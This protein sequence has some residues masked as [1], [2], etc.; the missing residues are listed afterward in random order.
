MCRILLF[1]HKRE[2]NSA[3]EDNLNGPKGITLSEISQKE[4]GKYSMISLTYG[5]SKSQKLW[6]PRAE[7][8][9]QGLWGREGGWGDA[10]QR[11]QTLSCKISKLWRSD[12]WC[13]DY[14]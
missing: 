3:I 8:C 10:A 12:A 1:S 9:Q 2:K 7:Q 11:T 6:K 4:K 13:G 5:F 14:S